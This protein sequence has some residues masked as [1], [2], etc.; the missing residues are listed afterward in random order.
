MKRALLRAAIICAAPLSRLRFVAVL[1]ALIAGGGV[2]AESIVLPSSL[3]STEGSSSNAF[4]FDY[5]GL[6]GHANGQRYQQVYASGGFPSSPVLISQISFRPDAQFGTA[7]STT[8]SSI[9]IQ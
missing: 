8:L 5:S 9:L 3:A 2:R 6:L 1:F 4:P 7:F